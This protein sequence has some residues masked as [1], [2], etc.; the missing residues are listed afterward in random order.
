VNHPDACSIAARGVPKLAL[1]LERL[2]RHARR[3]QSRTCSRAAG[4][5]IGTAGFVSGRCALIGNIG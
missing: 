1:I 2:E 5:G 3:S 4:S